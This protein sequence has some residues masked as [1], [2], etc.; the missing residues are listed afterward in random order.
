MSKASSTPDDEALDVLTAAQAAPAVT[1]LPD[2]AVFPIVG[3]GASAGGL[4]ACKTFVETVPAPSGMAFILVQHLDPTH[5]SMMVELLAGHT[6]LTVRQATDGMLIEPDNFY[7]IA[8]GTYLGVNEGALVVSAPSA[9]HGARLPFDYLLN[10]MA[11]QLG[12]RA[13][14]V[15]LSG[16]G[17]DGAAGLKAVK[18]RG[19]LVIAQEPAEAEYDGMPRSAI[20]TG[21]VDLVL[22]ASQIAPALVRHSQG[23]SLIQPL[24]DPLAEGATR[25][26][27]SRIIDLLLTKTAHDF[28][29]YKR[30]TLARRVERRMAMAAVKIH[31][32]DGYLAFLGSDAGEVELL[33]KDLLINVTNF[34]RDPKVFDLVES[35]IIPDLVNA[36]AP[37]QTLRVWIPGCSTGEEAYSLSMLLLERI[38]ASKVRTKLQVFA[39]DIDADAVAAAREGLYPRTIEADI[40]PARLAKFFTREET[41][42]RISTQLRASVVFTVQDV[43]ADPPFSRID[44][45]SCRNLLIYLR[46]EAQAKV[47]GLFHFALRPGGVLLLGSSETIADIEG[48]FEVVSKPARLYRQIGRSRPADLHFPTVPGD[49]RNPARRGADQ[50]GARPA[51]HAALCQR[52][53]LD[54]YAPAAVLIDHKHN[55]LYSVGP[56]SRYLELAVGFPNHDLLAVA[57]PNV[58]PNLRAALQRAALEK[59]RVVVAGIEMVRDAAAAPFSI[60]VEPV[61][62]DGEDLLLVCFIEEP[63]PEVRPR[64]SGVPARGE[65]PRIRQ[66]EEELEDARKELRNAVHERESSNE[67]Q[68]AVNEEALS[69]N[70]EFQATNEELVASK[71]ELQSLNEELTALNAQVQE[72]LERQR[73]TSND[74]Q[75]VLYS[76]DVATLFLDTD[77]KIRFFT[78]AT[79]SIFSVIPGDIGRPLEDLSALTTDANLLK[80]ARTVLQTLEPI[81]HE[82]EGR[83]GAWFTRRVL[84]YRTQGTRAEGVVITY[85]DVTDRRHASEAVGAAKKQADLANAAKSRFLAAASH[86]LRQPLQTSVLIQGLLAKIVEGKKPQALV[87]RLADSLGSMSEMLNA[88]LDINQIDAGTVVVKSVDLPIDELLERLRSEFTYSAQAQNLV[89][90]VVPCGLSVRTDPRL[91][92]Q[93][94]RNLVSNALKYTRRGRVLL[95]C[96]RRAGVLSVEVWDTGIGIPAED[97]QSIFEEYHQLDN[98]ARERSRGLGLGLSIV[99]QLGKLMDHPVRVR[100]RPGRGSVFAIEIPLTADHGAHPVMPS[101]KQAIGAAA[102]VPLRTGSILVIEDDPDVRELLELVLEREGHGVAT[103]T[104]GASALDLIGRGSLRPDIILADYNLPNGMTGVKAASKLQAKLGVKVPAIILTGDISTRALKVIADEGYTQLNKPV[105]LHE[106][107]QA[108]QRLLPPAKAASTPDGL[109]GLDGEDVRDGGDGPVIFIV[110]D[111]HQLRAAL[112][113]LLEADGRIVEDFADCEAFLRAVRPGQPG[114][115]LLD[116]YLPGM[117]GLELLSR[118]RDLRHALPVIMI[119]GNSDIAMAVDAMKAGASDFI[120]KPVRA[121]ELLSSIDRAL[122]QGNDAG[123]LVARREDAATRLGL[124]TRR[125]REIMDLVLAGYPS[126]NIAADLQISQRTVENHRAS[127]MKKTGSRSLPALA[128]LALAAASGDAAVLAV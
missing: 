54:K 107:N 106:L 21:L 118:L 119:T 76:T 38:T 58:R 85:V 112:R 36:A 121:A 114:C 49:A 89:L 84:P 75:N 8:P 26:A 98:P 42:Y 96:R 77:L 28:R 27:L 83:N 116:A 63:K 117:S 68:K 15:V 80:D 20:A 87:E 37:D 97:L 13:V 78:P 62:S 103:A 123:E 127:I 74:L 79:K 125:Q 45:V 25:S 65:G 5:E 48:R 72:T 122:E 33:A 53:V 67:E 1:T 71:E 95:G 110:D 47:I 90:R 4:V 113:D 111:D 12:S 24:S 128:R 32:L 99:Q 91:L 35:E 126:K 51:L 108:I 115:L 66:L 44:L 39:S 18:D 6:A 120:E 124:L 88:L 56:I 17:A 105:Q 70:E 92:E 109:D 16:T 104:D 10:S 60:A 7:V 23:H 73:T 94:I 46:P 3:I 2:E 40:S 93:M 61:D 57:R 55:C 31:D 52:L 81:E 29:L 69:V 9:R 19:G 22:P 11:E 43:L 82:I 100:S 34:F 86:D 14:A 30:G 64:R 50:A 101:G 59:T 102:V 41:G